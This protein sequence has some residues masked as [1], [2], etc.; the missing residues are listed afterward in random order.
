MVWQQH[1]R[2]HGSLNAIFRCGEICV[3]FGTNSS[4]KPHSWSRL[5]VGC[6]GAHYQT[7]CARLP[8][9][10]AVS[11]QVKAPLG[12]LA[13]RMDPLEL[14]KEIR[15]TQKLAVLSDGGP[16]QR[17]ARQKDNLTRFLATQATAWHGMA[18]W[19]E[20]RIAW[21]PSRR[22]LRTC[23]KIPSIALGP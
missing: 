18:A 10:D 15:R 19:F 11:E 22:A 5:P 4:I 14:L 13:E 20:R 21:P 2:I 17:P 7:P 8:S 1:E 3:N 23:A 12:E 9:S 6:F 16:I